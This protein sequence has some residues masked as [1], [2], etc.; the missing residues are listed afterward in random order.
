MKLTG[1]GEP[2]FK[3][4]ETYEED[5]LS[6]VKKAE[7]INDSTTATED[8]DSSN[9]SILPKAKKAKVDGAKIM[10]ENY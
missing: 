5:L 3:K 6:F 10:S 4:M 2:N 7:P 8:D 9:I 1:G